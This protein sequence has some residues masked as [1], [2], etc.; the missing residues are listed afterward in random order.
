MR[1]DPSPGPAWRPGRKRILLTLLA[2][3]PGLGPYAMTGTG[4]GA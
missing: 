1:C 2:A 4:T 3:L